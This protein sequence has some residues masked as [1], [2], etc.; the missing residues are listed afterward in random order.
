M[1]GAS[2]SNQGPLQT[3][4]GPRHEKGAADAGH[5]RLWGL[6]PAGDQQ[7]GLMATRLGHLGETQP[8]VLPQQPPLSQP[9][10]VLQDGSKGSP[11]PIVTFI[12]ILRDCQEQ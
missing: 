5:G 1:G 12:S 6:R 2:Q 4:A 10:G 9:T 3:E 11:N 7:E 8:Q